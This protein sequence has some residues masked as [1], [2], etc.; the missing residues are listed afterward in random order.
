MRFEPQNTNFKLQNIFQLPMSR[1]MEYTWA[2]HRFDIRLNIRLD[3][4][5]NICLDIPLNI[6]LDIEAGQ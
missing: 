6:R 3:I 4:P 5:L 2:K 1:L